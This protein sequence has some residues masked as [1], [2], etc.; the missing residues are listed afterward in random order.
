VFPIAWERK[1]SMKKFHS[2]TKFNFNSTI[3]L[4]SNSIKDKWDANFLRMYSKSSCEYDI[5]KKKH[6]Y[7]KTPFHAFSLENGLNKFQLGIVMSLNV[8]IRILS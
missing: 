1:S 6:K 4:N 2:I 7:E 3:E 8:E 5:G